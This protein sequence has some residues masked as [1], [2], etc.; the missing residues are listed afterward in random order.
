MSPK[1]VGRWRVGDLLL[2]VL[3]MLRTAGAGLLVASRKLLEAVE[4]K[5]R[6][7]Y[8]ES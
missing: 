2:Q 6:L 5:D 8:D 4:L 1:A 3:I 7:M